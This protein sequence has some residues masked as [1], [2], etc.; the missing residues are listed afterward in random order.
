MTTT[1]ANPD[2]AFKCLE[3]CQ[4]LASQGQGF[5]LTVNV[6]STFSFSLDSRK[7]DAFL[8]NLAVQSKMVRKKKLTPSQK[9]RNLLRKE[10]FLKK[11]RL[12]K[13][14]QKKLRQPRQMIMAGGS[15]RL[16]HTAPLWASPCQDPTVWGLDMGLVPRQ[17]FQP[18]SCDSC[19]L[20]L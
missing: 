11:R 17:V 4:L 12:R 16:A 9:R 6:G 14:L 8:E 10:K 15:A 7:K 1:D 5:S 18:H 2:L 13:L 20:Y 3:L 19:L